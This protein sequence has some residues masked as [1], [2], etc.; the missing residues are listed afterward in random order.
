MSG[1]VEGLFVYPEPGGPAEPRQTVRV[2]AGRGIEGD[3]RRTAHR[4]VTVI[5]LDDVGFLANQCEVDTQ[6]VYL[7]TDVFVFAGSLRLADNR[8]SETWMRALL[9]GL[10]FGLMNTTTDNQSTHCLFARAALQKQ[11]VFVNNIAFVRAFCPNECGD[12]GFA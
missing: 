1:R 9:S 8:L 5:S 11:L 4:A 10:T 12:I 2:V 3:Q 6:N 7:A